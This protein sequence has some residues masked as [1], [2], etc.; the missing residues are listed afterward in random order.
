MYLRNLLFFLLII[1]LYSS[2]TILLQGLGQT[3]NDSKMI[4][5]K[6]YHKLII[7]EL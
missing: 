7:T 3:K 2:N 4:H 5:H 1:K 6:L